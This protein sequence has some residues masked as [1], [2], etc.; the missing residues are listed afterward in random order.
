MDEL[1]GGNYPMTMY[2]NAVNSKA[3]ARMLIRQ[4][5]SRW[6]V[7]N[8]IT[9]DRGAQ[10]VSD[11]WR[12]ICQ[13]MGRVVCLYG[14]LAGPRW[15]TRHLSSRSPPPRQWRQ[16]ACSP[17]HRHIGHHLIVSRLTA[18]RLHPGP[19]LL[20][21][22]PHPCP[23]PRPWPG[24][25]PQLVRHPLPATPTAPPATVQLPPTAPAP[26]PTP[27]PPPADRRLTSHHSP[28]PREAPASPK[29]RRTRR[30]PRRLLEE[31]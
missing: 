1:A 30:P 2:G 3:C 24:P 26:P 19:L 10:F 13:L 29:P 17:R 28:G 15:S 31:M 5:I 21:L 23:D 11:L 6:G 25:N 20:C 16:Q 9:S 14:H 27:A 12:K 22:R 7:H 4:W 18:R 8:V